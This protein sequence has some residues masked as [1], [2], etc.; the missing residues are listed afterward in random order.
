[1]KTVFGDITTAKKGIIVHQVNAQ[2]VMGSGVAK[3]LRDKW[4]EVYM[5][6]KQHHDENYKAQDKGRSLLGDV[7][8][9]IVGDG[10]AVA[11]LVGQ[12]FYGREKNRKYTSYDALDKGFADI[13]NMARNCIEIGNKD[14]EVHFPLIGAGLGGGNWTTISS[15]IGLHFDKIPHALWIKI[16]SD[17]LYTQRALNKANHARDILC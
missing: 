4:P 1:M 16:H 12:Q 8:Y 2:G 3:A 13:A 6:Y 15:L 17:N 9:A 11:N 10:L 14:I 7:S 5:V